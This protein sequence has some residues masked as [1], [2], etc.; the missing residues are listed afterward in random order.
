MIQT[1]FIKTFGC[2]QNESDSERI[3]SYF[4]NRGFGKAKGMYQAD[5]VVINTCMIREMAE[6]RVYG[7]VNNLVKNKLKMGKPGKIVVTG[8]MVGMAARDKSGVFMKLIRKRMPYVDEFLP[9]EEVGFDHPP[10]RSDTVN[11]WVPV[12][13][14]CNN[15]CTFCV[16]PFTRGREISRP[17][18][19]ILAECRKLAAG[20]FRKIT[21]LGMNVNSY[22]AD[23]IVGADNVQVMRD[24]GRKYFGN[25]SGKM[26]AGYVLPDGRKV[27]P[28]LVTHLGRLRIPTLFPYLLEDIC[29]I[30]GIENIDFMSS[31]PWDFSPELIGTIAKNPKITRKLHLAV[32]SGSDTVLK[33][34]NRWY[35]RSE[36]LK[37][38]RTMREK[39]KGVEFSTDIIVGFCGET[40]KE[41]EE[42]LDLAKK[43]KFYKAY[44]AMYSDRPGTAAH[45]AFKDD[46][47]HPL[48]K[49][50]WQVLEKMINKPYVESLKRKK[51]PSKAN[52]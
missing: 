31:N 9:I 51:I 22:G 27:K 2:Q 1:Y 20:G 16:V 15:F 10:L 46:V 38:L 50:R 28:V 12:S 3:A 7:T 42:T 23:L 6:N 19:D 17:Y 33:R 35:K 21:L 45:K 26:P 37:L 34:M 36:F 4:R 5:T 44:I 8:C 47:P 18:A 43:A 30:E 40:D 48:K 41:F 39:I 11:A 13:N 49:K 32:Q 14:G 29:A 24:I 25:K 52:R